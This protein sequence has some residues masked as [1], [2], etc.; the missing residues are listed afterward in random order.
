VILH[1]CFAWRQRG[2]AAEPDGPLWFPRLFQGDGRHDNPDVYG[3]LYVSENETSSVAEQLG[4][5]RG[6]RLV[7]SMLLRRGLPLAVAALELADDARII[8]LD[9][10][11]VLTANRLRPSVVAT[12][13]REITQPQARELY[14]RH[15]EAAALRWWSTYESLWANVT[16][17]DRG[18]A[19]LRVVDVRMLTTAD[20]TVVTAAEL[21]G[22]QP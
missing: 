17:F 6:Q 12:R 10:P 4:R 11:R 9:E 14:E 16:L 1:R 13:T 18:A 8:D 2:P 5:F 20:E 22:I 15:P 19:A 3:C 7:P 21:L